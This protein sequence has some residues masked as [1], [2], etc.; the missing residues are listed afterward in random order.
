MAQNSIQSITT[1]PLPCK[2]LYQAKKSNQYFRLEQEYAHKAVV[3]RSFE[4]YKSQV[5]ELYK[6]NPASQEM[7]T[8]LLGGSIETIAK[9]PAEVLDNAKSSSHPLE[10]IKENL[11]GLIDPL[12]KLVETIKK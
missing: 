6:D 12:S 11:S 4:G 8:K 10:D 3:S 1:K 9:N 7:L 5:L 2:G